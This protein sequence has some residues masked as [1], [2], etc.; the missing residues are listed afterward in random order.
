M[1]PE[2]KRQLLSRIWL[3]SELKEPELAMLASITEKRRYDARKTIVRQ[4]D[5]DGDFYCVLRGH[6]KVTACDKH[7]HEIVMNLLQ[8]NDSF[9]EIAFFDG[10]ARSATVTAIDACEL[11]VIRRADFW[12]VLGKAPVI[13]TTLVTALAK[14]VRRLSERA[15][16]SAFLDVRAR[17]AKCLNDLADQF[18][19]RLGPQQVVISVRLSQQELG[20]MVQATRESVN[21]C[22]SEWTKEGIIQRSG[23]RIII[24][25]RQRLRDLATR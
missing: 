11:L 15:E 18:G 4:G 10:Q 22:L 5:L 8:P 16:D 1:T 7:G 13:A 6:L 21:K 25:D 2:E 19:T 12:L 3:F 17:L 23:G 24:E 9:G 14:L 20:D